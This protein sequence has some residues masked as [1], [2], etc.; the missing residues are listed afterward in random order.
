M[1]TTLT[2]DDHLA[3]QLREKA[4]ERGISFKEM[5]NSAIRAGLREDAR[6]SDLTPYRCRT[7]SMGY[8]KGGLAK[9]LQLASELENEEIATKMSVRK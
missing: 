8:P 7:F 3:K 9:A 4:H 5:V 6:P 1:R 2:L